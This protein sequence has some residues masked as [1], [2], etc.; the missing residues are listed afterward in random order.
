MKYKVVASPINNLDV[1]YRD[2][3]AVIT[4]GINLTDITG[5]RIE[6]RTSSSLLDA[7]YPEIK[8]SAYIAPVL[9]S[10]YTLFQ[11]IILLHGKKK[12]HISAVVVKRNQNRINIIY[13]YLIQYSLNTLSFCLTSC[14]FVFLIT[15]RT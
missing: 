11:E 13:F 1:A 3:F 15:T 10:I 2:E 4:H 6:E 7:N 8:N 12:L 5:T 9:F 14:T